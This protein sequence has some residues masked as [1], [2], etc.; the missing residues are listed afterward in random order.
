M[1]KVKLLIDRVLKDVLSTI[2][3]FDR[4]NGA[5][6]PALQIEMELKKFEVFV[7]DKCN[8]SVI[9]NAREQEDGPHTFLRYVELGLWSLKVLEVVTNGTG[10]KTLADGNK[11]QRSH[12]T[13]RSCLGVRRR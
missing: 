4:K 8:M 11:R 12:D 9:T 2:F 1:G 10:S 6:A 3:V 7:F 13:T 5:Q